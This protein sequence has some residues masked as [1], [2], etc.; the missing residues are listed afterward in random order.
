MKKILL[1]IFTVVFVASGSQALA[2]TKDEQITLLQNQ[3]NLIQQRLDKL[4]KTSKEEEDRITKV[5]GTASD[6]RQTAVVANQL[7]KG[8]EFHGYLR[9]GFGVNN[10]GGKMRKF[11]IPGG[12]WKYRLG[13]ATGT[14][15]EA[16][17]VKNWLN[18]GQKDTDPYFNTNVMMAYTTDSAKV[19]DPDHEHLTI[20]QAYAQMGNLDFAPGVS[21]WAGERY[22]RRHDIYAA[23]FFYLDMSAYGGGVEDLPFIGQSKMAIAYLGGSDND[24]LLRNTG[25]IAKNSFDIRVYDIPLP[26]GK[27]TVWFAPSWVNGGNYTQTYRDSS[28]QEQTSNYVYPD[29]KGY[30]VGVLH[31]TKDFFGLCDGFNHFSLQYGRGTG[32]DY[33]PYVKLDTDSNGAK[34]PPQRLQ[35]RWKFRITDSSVIQVSKK[36]SIAPIFIYQRYNDG[37]IQSSQ[38]NAYWVSA[39]FRPQYNLTKNFALVFDAGIDHVNSRQA[40]ANYAGNLFKVGFAPTLTVDGLFF[41]RPQISAFVTYAKWTRGLRG[42]IGADGDNTAFNDLHGMNAGIA[43]SA[44]W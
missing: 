18:P 19:N 39:G 23:D 2:L 3:L 17:F 34:T 13:N 43:V 6:A 38:A 15:G 44:W 11:Q 14:Y 27:G 33:K 29:A 42:L 35:Q 1:G 9:S 24:V 25:Y 20:R 40:T 26:V 21:F 8:F 41:S 28:G 37:A 22:Y 31:E 16:M 5:E 36:F 12:D 4:E 10:K 30:A 7:A 32:A